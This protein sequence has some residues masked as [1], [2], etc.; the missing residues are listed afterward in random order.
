M[1]DVGF[2]QLD[3][4]IKRVTGEA[5]PTPYSPSLEKMVVPSAD[6]IARAIR[7]LVEE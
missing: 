5:C 2:D 4:P 6:T 3:A 7:E 1:A